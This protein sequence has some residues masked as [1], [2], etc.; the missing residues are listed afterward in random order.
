MHSYPCAPVYA[1]AEKRCRIGRTWSGPVLA[2]I[3][4]S[5]PSGQSLSGLAGLQA[6]R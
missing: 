5:V 2:P 4:G 6:C 1:A 3:V